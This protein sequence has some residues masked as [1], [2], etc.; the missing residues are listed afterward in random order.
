M[1]TTAAEYLELIAPQFNARANWL[2]LD[3]VL[4]TGNTI[5]CTVNGQT[6]VALFA[7]DSDTTL[8]A[9]VISIA[10]LPIVS[11]ATRSGLVITVTTIRDEILLSAI[12]TGGATQAVITTGVLNTD[13]QDSFLSLAILQTNELWY[14]GKYNYAIALRAAHLLQLDA[15]NSQLLS[16]GGATAAGNGSIKS[17]DQGDLAIAYGSISEN[18]SGST[19]GAIKA[20]LSRTQYGLTLFALRASANFSMM[21]S[22]SMSLGGTNG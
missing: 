14:K 10:A 18:D 22:G 3:G 5:S 19:R 9:F 16:M 20:D 8:D 2:S 6:A 4:V 13:T 17:L 1:A 15:Q 7:T 21:T 12:V 11:T